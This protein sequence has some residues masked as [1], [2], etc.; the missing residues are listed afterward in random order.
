MVTDF[1][2]QLRQPR[3]LATL[4]FIVAALIVFAYAMV[5]GITLELLVVIFAL[6]LISNGIEFAWWGVTRFRQSRQSV[7]SRS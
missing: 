6:G 7:A 4:P 3:R 5:A 1:L 2:T